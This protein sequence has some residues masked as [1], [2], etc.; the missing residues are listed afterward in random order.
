MLP[1]RQVTTWGAWKS[2]I[3]DEAE[4]SWLVSERIFPFASGF[5]LSASISFILSPPLFPKYSRQSAMRRIIK[6]ALILWVLVAC[7]TRSEAKGQGSE[8]SA[9]APLLNSVSTNDQ[10]LARGRLIERV[11]SRS[12]PSQ[13]Y[14]LYLPSSYTPEKR[15]PI[16]YCF[17][18]LARGDIPVERFRDAAEK[19]GW[20]VVGSH[21]SRNGPLKPSF[22]ATA[23]MWDDTHARL[24]IDERRVY[25]AGFSGGARLAVRF[26]Y[27]CRGCLAGVIAN[28][29]GFPADIKISPAVLFHVF[30]IA[31]T[32]DFNFPEMKNLDEAL[33]KLSLPHRL[34]IFDG[35]HTWA[36]AAVCTDAV[37]WMELQAMKTG[38]RLRD[39]ALIEQFWQKQRLRAREA[40]EADKLFE[41]YQSYRIAAADFRGLRNVAET[42]QTAARLKESREVRRALDEESEQG[43]RQQRLA[44]ELVALL[45]ERRDL[46]NGAVA[47][48]SF[49]KAVEDLKRAARSAADT[50][51]RRVAR[52][53]LN[54][55]F[56][57]FYEGATNLLQRRENYALAASSLAAAAELAPDNPQILYE[58]A[59]AY[60]LN[61]DKRRAF[62]ALRKAIEKGFKDVTGMARNDAF[63]ALRKDAE[64]QKLIDSINLK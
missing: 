38:K 37:E 47:S 64:F 15:W 1:H 3:G 27:F 30:A 11:A 46:N 20:I 43:T 5:I 52:R 2:N 60:A 23:M 63:A 57:Q 35:A 33:G 31:G 28:G 36:P 29:A 42:E 48:I 50:G 53:A 45:E 24:S 12:D 34:A 32:D 17:D 21:N 18:P 62:D 59:C 26:G 58:L 19:Y 10:P 54:Q 61:R 9:P 16:L 22:E 39:E 7:F 51:E 6:V 13:S 44:G 49:K 8:K 40:E 41:A 14:A 56:A 4:S 25:A 55:V